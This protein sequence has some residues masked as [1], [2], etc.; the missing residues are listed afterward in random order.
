MAPL[1]FAW[2]RRALR[3]GEVTCAGVTERFLDVIRSKNPQLNAL[4]H[5]DFDQARRQAAA[6]DEAIAQG[7]DLPLAGMI[8]AIK[9]V[10]CTR[11]WPV[12][13]SSSILNKFQPTYDAT[14]VARLRKAGVVFIGRANCDE[15]A[16]GSTNETSCY[17]P[18]H[19]PSHPE[20][21]PG[22]SSGGS[23]VAVAAGMCHGAIGTDT[24][25]SVR[26]PAAFCGVVGLKPTYGRVSR[27]GL[28]AYASSFDC[29]GTLTNSV[30]DAAQILE[31]IQG[32][33]PLDATST[34][35]S[36]GLKC[37]DTELPLRIGMPK[38]YYGDGLKVEVR[39]AIGQL[40]SELEANGHCVEPVSLPHTAYGV[41]AYYV[42]AAA[43]ASSN[44]ARYDGIRY[45][46]R[47]QPSGGATVDDLYIASR[48]SGFGFEVKRRIM[49]GT[50]VLSSGYY[51]A[52][53][54]KAQRVRTLVKEDF[55][56]A[57]EKVD[58]LLTP[59]TPV[60]GIKLGAWGR[61]PLKMYLSDIYTVTANLAG[62]PGMSVPMGR[63]EGGLPAAVQLLAGPFEEAKLLR[64]GQHIMRWR[65][66]V[67]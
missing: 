31:V 57:F 44:L 23:A 1:T 2:T 27:S 48:S 36:T 37:D 32:T 42:L 40:V 47:K 61:D 41:A 55:D 21:V 7:A 19:H 20:F 67:G 43:E 58:V 65:K 63:Y 59:V 24:G 34:S 28:I 13:C 56:R 33:D 16:M 60:R 12:T 30:E 15:F 10:L 38:E 51:E 54:G 35:D 53:Y 52:Y 4:T 14:A 17:G 22:G 5:V 9:D 39:D 64:M 29:V 3:R 45:G 66:T 49:L 25:G 8:L 11:D 50:Y 46:S 62:I 18:T 26:Q 6:V